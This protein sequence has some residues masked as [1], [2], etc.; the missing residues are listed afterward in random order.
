ME[1]GHIKKSDIEKA[2][3]YIDVHAVPREYLLNQYWVVVNNKEYPF[4]YLLRIADRLSNPGSNGLDFRSTP[5]NRQH[6]TEMELETH[7]YPG[8]YNFFNIQDFDFFTE[9]LDRKYRNGVKADEL[10][11]KR[12]LTLFNKTKF[13]ADQLS[14][15]GFE[16]KKDGLWQ[17]SGKFKEYT[18]ARIFRKGQKDR[19]IFFT[20]GVSAAKRE[21]VYKIDCQWSQT[22]KNHAL[23]PAM[24]NRFNEYMKVS[25]NLHLGWRSIPDTLIH[26]YDWD[27]L[28]LETSNF[29]ES[30][31]SFF[32]D[33]VE[34][35]WEKNNPAVPKNQRNE[36]REQNFPGDGFDALPERKA[37]FNGV[38]KDFLKE[39]QRNKT[40]G[41][42]GEELVLKFEKEKL[43]EAGMPGLA[44]LVKKM[45]DGKGYDILSFFPDEREKHIE[46]KTTTAGYLKPFPISW[47]EV[48]YMKVAKDC[49]CLYRLYNF[50]PLNNSADFFLI[51]KDVI[52]RLL[53]RELTYEAFI[54]K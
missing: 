51:E 29:I 33:L 12:I 26:L 3:D 35:V 41:D 19:K 44:A 25:N 38:D 30:N 4:K 23:S 1:V 8:W 54:G 52:H 20:V 13:W 21:L 5:E 10:L 15:E 32:D 28:I 42:A 16:V 37:L 43:I 24:V 9:V 34:Y 11:G 45:Q 39:S 6:I 17:I 36:L 18:W 40:F 49:Y 46:V 47:N 14:L 48:E 53:F 27:K 31:L 2:A 22:N 7:Y 50:D